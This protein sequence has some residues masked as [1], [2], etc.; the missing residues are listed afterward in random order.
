M[1][2]FSRR[3]ALRS[4]LALPIGALAP[5]SARRITDVVSVRDFGAAG[6]G[7]SDDTE[8][9]RRALASGADVLVPPAPAFYRIRHALALARPGQHIRGSAG[10]S[11]IVQTGAHADADVFV[12]QHDDCVFENLHL[13]PGTVTAALANGWGIIVA[14]AGRASVTGCRVSGMRRGGVLLADAHDCRVVGNHFAESVVSG[15]D[16]E[17]QADTGYDIF[18]MGSASRNEIRRNECLSGVGVGVGC[19]TATRGKSQSG[20][21]IVDNHIAN[22]PGYGIMVYR[23]EVGDHIHGVVIEDNRIENISGAIRTDG[24]T[25][26]YGCGIYVASA[27]HFAVVGNRVFNT[28]M[29][30][31]LPFYGSAVPAGIGVSGYGDGIVRGNE[32]DGCYNGIA[33]IQSTERGEP[34]ELTRIEENIVRRC[35][36]TG[37]LLIDSIGAEVL[38]NR[39]SGGPRSAQGIYAAQ[40]LADHRARLAVTENVIEGFGVG[41]EVREQHA[42][43]EV[44][45]NVVR[46]NRGHAIF[47]A[48]EDM[49]I[50]RNQASG[51]AVP[52]S[53]GRG[54]V[55]DNIL[56]SSGFQDGTRGRIRRSGNR[57]PR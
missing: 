14:G 17:R 49:A 24:R 50:H 1:M 48:A 35:D 21:V 19:Q 12:T 2:V 54:I 18:L 20:N 44:T 15:G 3:L 8:A 37:V 11:R 13:T 56:G 41:I 40:A 23:S 30:R 34:G 36:H 53:A 38:K 28:N 25:R 32:I 43:A 5:S 27:N 51:I 46:G 6:D 4:L 7:V 39:L 42:F 47:C 52:P 26:F 22:Q 29:D 55:S 16:R 33:S 31:R 57:P 9:F 10:Q 45:G